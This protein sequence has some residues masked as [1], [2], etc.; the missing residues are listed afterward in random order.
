VKRGPYER[1]SGIDIPQFVGQQKVKRNE[2][3]IARESRGRGRGRGGRGS[4]AV[5][6]ERVNGATERASEGR[7]GSRF[8]LSFVLKK[9]IR[10]QKRG[11]MKGTRSQRKEEK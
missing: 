7:R 4:A 2:V 6:Q 11:V 1:V 3:E 9:E 8:L 10:G 5:M